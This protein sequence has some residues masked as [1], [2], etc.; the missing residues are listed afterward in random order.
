MGRLVTT[1]LTALL[2]VPSLASADPPATFRSA[3]T[4]AL[5]LY[6]DHRETFY[7]GCLFD[8]RKLI[9]PDTCGYEFEG[10]SKGRWR[11]EWEHIVPRSRLGGSRPHDEYLRAEAELMNLRPVLAE[12]NR[13]RSDNPFGIVSGEPRRWGKCD[14]EVARGVAEPR[15]SVRGD[16][17]RVHLYMDR[18]YGIGLTESEWWLFLDWS[19]ADPPDA[20]ELE[21][22]RRVRALD[23]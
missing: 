6:D 16:I 14:F 19:S 22:R 8:Q 20:W 23:D 21:Y 10:T 18:K 11:I 7:C 1:L 12:L 4:V 5:R 2:A 3:K 13:A 17:A 9:Y 15:E